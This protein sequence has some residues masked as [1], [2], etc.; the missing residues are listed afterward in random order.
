M[1]QCAKVIENVKFH[2]EYVAKTMRD[3]MSCWV[4]KESF[5]DSVVG[6]GQDKYLGVGTNTSAALFG[7]PQKAAPLLLREKLQAVAEKVGTLKSVS[8]TSGGKTVRHDMTPRYATGVA[9]QLGI[10]KVAC[11]MKPLLRSECRLAV[12]LAPRPQKHK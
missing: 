7:T 2:G 12:R 8:I 9:V 11:G 10:C 3:R 1:T 6:R 5:L 4:N